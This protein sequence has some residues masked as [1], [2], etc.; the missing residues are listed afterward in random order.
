MD[1]VGLAADATFWSTWAMTTKVAPGMAR[2][3]GLGKVPT[4][5][6]QAAEAARAR[7]AEAGVEVDADG[8]VAFSQ[9]QRNLYAASPWNQDL[10][11]VGQLPHDR[12]QLLRIM[13][14]RL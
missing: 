8:R 3:A 10:P 7:L 6:V 12:F 9:T 13:K 14:S 11:G 1:A 2:E 5:D 4:A